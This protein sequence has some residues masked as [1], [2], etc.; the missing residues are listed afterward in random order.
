LDRAVGLLANDHSG[1][2]NVDT[3]IVW[4]VDTFVTLTTIHEQNN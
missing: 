4:T 3:G 2:D 1:A